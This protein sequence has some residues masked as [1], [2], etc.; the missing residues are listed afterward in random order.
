VLEYYDPSPLRREMTGLLG[1]V[2]NDDRNLLMEEKNSTI[3]TLNIYYTD[4]GIASVQAVYTLHTDH[5]TVQG[6]TALP[7]IFISNYCKIHTIDTSHDDFI[8]YFKLR[9]HTLEQRIT[10]IKIVTNRNVKAGFGDNKIKG[11]E[12]YEHDPE[13]EKDWVFDIDA[14]EF[15]VSLFVGIV[16]K[17]PYWYLSGMGV[18]IS[19]L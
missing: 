7:A 2:K 17:G 18:E 9:Y 16:Q 3:R 13:I 14:N 8:R 19:N 4:R 11:E 10:S 15:P 6:K 5:T 1:D 12:Q